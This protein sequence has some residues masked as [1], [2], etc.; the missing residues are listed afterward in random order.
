MAGSLEPNQLLAQQQALRN[1]GLERAKKT[2]PDK[3]HD[4]KFIFIT[5]G[6]IVL[7]CAA[8]FAIPYL[9]DALEWLLNLL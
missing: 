1:I 3:K 5:I 4:R 6:V 7:I 8:C 2:K 9:G